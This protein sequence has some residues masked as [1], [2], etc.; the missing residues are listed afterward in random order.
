M[1]EIIETRRSIRKFK[2]DPIPEETVE[3]IMASAIWAP[4]AMNRQNW[5]F[6]VFTEEMR[7]RLAILHNSIF[8][9]VKDRI[10]EHYGDEGVEIRRN[11]YMNFSGAPVAIVCFTEIEDREKPKSDIISAAL[12]CE[13]LILQAH[14][15]G[16]G[17]LPMTSS[18]HISDEISFLCGVD[19]DKM[20]LIMVILLGYPDETPEPPLRRRKRVVHASQPGDIKH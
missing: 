9:M 12:A 2:T 7:D 20:D 6:F 17:T 18:H 5:K 8:E 13:N 1:H 19:Q 3:R 16:I 10:R 14:S 11:L 15:M 4:S